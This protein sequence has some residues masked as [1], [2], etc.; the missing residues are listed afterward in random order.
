MLKKD[1]INC[2]IR[3]K[4]FTIDAGDIDEVLGLEGLDDHDFTN[5][6]DRKISIETVQ[7]RISGVKKGRCLNTNAF[8]AD[9]RCL[10]TIMMFNFYLVRKLTTINNA[11]A[12][13]LMEFKENTFIDISSHIFDTIVD[14][15]RTTSRAKLIFPSLLMR[16]F[17]LK[18]VEIPQ[19]ISLLPA[20]LAINK[21]TITRI[22]VRLPGDEKEGEPMETETEAAGEP[23]SSRGRGKRSRILELGVNEPIIDQNSLFTGMNYTTATFSRA[24]CSVVPAFAF[25]MAWI[26][27]LEKVNIR[28][29]CGHAKVLGTIVTVGG[30]MLMTLVKG[31]M[32]NLQWTNENGH[33]ESTS[34]ANKQDVIKGALMML[35]GFFCWSGF[36][37]LQEVTLKSYPA[38]LSLTILICLMGT[39]ESTILA[40]AMEWNNLTTWSIHLDAKLLATVYAGIVCSGFAI[41]LQGLI[42]KENGPVFVTAFTPLSTVLVAIIGSFILSETIYLGRVIGAIVIAMGLYMV[43]WGKSKDQQRSKSDNEEVAPTANMATMNERITTSKSM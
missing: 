12:I 9:M 23:S 35:A 28:R 11:R 10:T 15:T 37:I 1:E 29:L 3:G 27:G 8:P 21:Q 24:L 34:A 17:R 16:L 18:G 6:K 40:L 5:Y 14:K 2:W 13:F 32:L 20:L 30:A 36:V 26:L 7:S 43:L 38:E 39:L 41:Y 42:M 33:Q 4:E 22:Q 19:D 25:L 31:P